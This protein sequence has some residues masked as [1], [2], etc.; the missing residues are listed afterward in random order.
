LPT[1]LS[2]KPNVGDVD[3]HLVGYA[4]FSG[5]ISLP[6][7]SVGTT[8]WTVSFDY[9]KDVRP[10]TSYGN[11][12]INDGSVLWYKMTGPSVPDSTNAAATFPD[13]QVAILRGTGRFAGAKGDGT[14]SGA[15][16]GPP[17]LGALLWG[18]AV[19][20]TGK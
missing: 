19:I 4:R 5:F 20:N 10:H 6:D 16:I 12:T 7:G 8:S 9:T 15:R 1:P 17:G 2:F 11:V 13:G 14:A 3:G 18:D